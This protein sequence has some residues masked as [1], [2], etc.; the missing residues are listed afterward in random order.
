MGE[1]FREGAAGDR[2]FEGVVPLDTCILALN[3]VGS[4][5]GGEGINGGESEEVWLF[6]HGDGGS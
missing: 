6:A 1:G 5:G 3:D 4:E 2:D